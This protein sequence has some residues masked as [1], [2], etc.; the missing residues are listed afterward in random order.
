MTCVSKCRTR[1]FELVFP[2]TY[3]L[4]RKS[5]GKQYHGVR[6]GNVRLG[7]SPILDFGHRYFSSGIFKTEYKRFPDNFAATL[8]WT[9]PTVESAILWE[10]TVNSRLIHRAN[11]ENAAIGKGSSDIEKMRV[12]RESSCLNKYGVNHNFKVPSIRDKRNA[13]IEKLYGVKNV[14]SSPI[15]RKKVEET[16]IE[17]FGVPCS[18]QSETIKRKIRSTLLKKFGVDNPL[19]S[20]SVQQKMRK[21]CMRDFGVMFGFQRSD[22]K[23]K[24]AGRRIEMYI[25]LAKMTSIDFDTYL[26]TLSP[27]KCVQNQK[28]SQRLMGIKILEERH[29]G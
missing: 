2:Y 3:T 19:K 22:V 8:R 4:M 15:I 10:S 5:D 24:I 17:K 27:K 9:F 6:W 21:N 1:Q 26:S 25:R 11:W 12:R 13:T 29:N 16:S 23:E 14:G 7:L 28:K 20:A 18:F